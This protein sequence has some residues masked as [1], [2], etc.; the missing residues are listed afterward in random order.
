MT[1]FNEQYLVETVSLLKFA[2]TLVQTSKIVAG[3]HS[4][5]IVVCLVLNSLLLAAIQSLLVVRLHDT[6]RTTEVT[7]LFST[8]EVLL[9]LTTREYI[10]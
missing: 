9:K 5:A 3:G 7:K 2:Q 8:V 6:T 4:N 1:K 10:S